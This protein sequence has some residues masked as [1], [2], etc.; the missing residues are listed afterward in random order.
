MAKKK[1]TPH[2]IVPGGTPKFGSIYKRKLIPTISFLNRLALM[3]IFDRKNMSK[4]QERILDEGI[5]DQ[6]RKEGI[7]TSEKMELKRIIDALVLEKRGG[8]KDI[9]ESIVRHELTYQMLY[10]NGL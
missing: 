6:A 1:K 5:Q 7:T 2:I 3:Y 10:P 8:F 9:K 4:D